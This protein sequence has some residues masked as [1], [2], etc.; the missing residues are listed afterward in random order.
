MEARQVHLGNSADEGLITFSSTI[1]IIDSELLAL[2]DI[3]FI[4]MNIKNIYFIFLNVSGGD[5]DENKF[6]VDNLF[7]YNVKT[8]HLD[9]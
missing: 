5:G 8:S 7:L 2:Y 9:N 3:N 6:C 1:T 4:Y